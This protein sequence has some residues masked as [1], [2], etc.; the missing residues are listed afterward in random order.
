MPPADEGELLLPST[1][2][3]PA[4]PDKTNLDAAMEQTPSHCRQASMQAGGLSAHR[5][6]GRRTSILV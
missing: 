1:R 2:Y 6:H 3:R 4:N 5:Q